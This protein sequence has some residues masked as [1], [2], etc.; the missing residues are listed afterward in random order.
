MY[1]PIN[2]PIILRAKSSRFRRLV[3]VLPKT[4]LM[5]R[6]PWL[7]KRLYE[8][9]IGERVVEYPFTLLHIP[10]KADTVLDIGCCGSELPIELASLGYRVWGI[11]IRPYPL[12]HPGF[13]FIRGDICHTSFPDSFFDVVTAVST[14]E[15]IGLER[16]GEA[17]REEGDKEAIKEIARILKLGGR[18]IITVP[19]GEK[20]MWYHKGIPLARIYDLPSL[21][22]LLSGFKIERIGACVKEQGSWLLSSPEAA[23]HVHRDGREE[24]A[25]AL[26]VA[27]KK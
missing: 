9:F 19:F 24:K 18:L 8:L 20:D 22:G 14:L 16:Y 23:A 12:K 2:H 25:I 1:I 21:E 26:I 3:S 15:H 17:D 27:E 4:A 5:N 11:D 10:E 13:T 6:F 7:G